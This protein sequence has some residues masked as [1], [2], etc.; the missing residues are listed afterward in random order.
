MKNRIIIC[1]YPKS[2]N[3]WLT[4]L[5]AEIVG[6]PV[7]GFWC[8]PFNKD[9]AVEGV[10]RK[11][12]FECFKA[13]HSIDQLMRTLDI[14][15][16]GTEKIIYVYRDPRAVIVSASHYF[17]FPPD[18]PRLLKILRLFPKGAGFYYKFAQSSTHALD[19]MT[20]GL[21][22]GTTHGAWL[23]EPWKSHV[24]GYLGREDILVLSYESLTLDTLAAARH[25]TQFLSIDRSIVD[26]ENAI[27]VQ[28]F[29]RKKKQFQ[30]DGMKA[31]SDF[32][33][34]GKIDSWRDELP[35]DSI[36]YVEEKLGSFMRLLGYVISSDSD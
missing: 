19:I 25:I 1:G 5:T 18:H 4:R 26:L 29:E 16:N 6:C 31:N 15:G 8:E 2:G 35:V 27:C 30:A 20:K 3:T 32:L 28:S 22:R 36:K 24:A 17:V 11:S 10:D 33:R 14:Y 21:V 34:R 7:V 23:N 9:E 13:H 12:E